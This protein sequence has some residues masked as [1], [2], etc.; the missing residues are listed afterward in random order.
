MHNAAFRALGRD[1]LYVPFAVP[2]ERLPR[3]IEAARTL[4]VRGFNVTLPLKTDVMT[5]LDA[6]EPAAQAI[7]AVNT[8]LRDGDR[9]IGTNT[10]AGGLTRSLVAA[11]VKPKG[12]QAVVLGAGGAARAALFGLA[13]AGA[14]EIV[15]A[16]RRLEAAQRLVRELSAVFAPAQLA[17][18]NM[19]RGPLQTA[20]ERAGLLVQAS[21][22]TLGDTAEAHAFVAALPLGALPPGAAVCDLVYKPRTT[23][24]LASARVH[25]LLAVD[26]LGMLLH[27]GALAFERWT[28]VPAP[29]DAMGKA[30][31]G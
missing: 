2:P 3:A 31:A 23:A 19:E 6:L 24:L 9:L 11:G 7:G 18:C 25:G 28:G 4:D 21:S 1:A 5:L 10:D 20:F 15:V 30:L 12:V 26:G 13:E 29:L 16:A 14:T 8:V 17:A 22:A 27:Q